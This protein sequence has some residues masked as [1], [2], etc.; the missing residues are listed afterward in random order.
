M[1]VEILKYLA[2]SSSMAIEI[3]E[4]DTEEQRINAA[5]ASFYGWIFAIS[6]Y[7]FKCDKCQ[8]I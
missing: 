1:R 7:M 5:A 4:N 8:Y 3:F 2:L 6:L